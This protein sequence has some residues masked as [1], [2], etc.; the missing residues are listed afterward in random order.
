MI[1]HVFILFVDDCVLINVCQLYEIDSAFKMFAQ[2]EIIAKVTQ[3]RLSEINVRLLI[4]LTKLCL[5]LV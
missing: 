5:H 1:V 4:C 3:G 2:T